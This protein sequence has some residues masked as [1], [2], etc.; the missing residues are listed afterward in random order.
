[1]ELD[2]CDAVPSFSF[3]SSS[4]RIIVAFFVTLDLGGSISSMLYFEKE[5]CDLEF[6]RAAT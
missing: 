5:E 4:S 6:L 3:F 2:L 1:M